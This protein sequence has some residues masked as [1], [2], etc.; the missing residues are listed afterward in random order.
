[1]RKIILTAVFIIATITVTKAQDVRF[2][3]R[4]GVNFTTPSFEV[5]DGTG[6]FSPNTKSGTSFYIGGLA[7]L[8]LHSISEEFRIELQANFT[9]NSFEFEKDFIYRTL[10]LTQ[11]KIPVMA[12]YEVIENGFVKGGFYGAF[13]LGGEYTYKNRTESR[14]MA[15]F[16]YGIPLGLEYNLEEGLFFEAL[17]NIGFADLNDKGS[18][19]EILNRSIQIGIGYKF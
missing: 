6:T 18:K 4:G 8:P 14:D 5:T 12:K 13:T 9:K 11:I 2:G 10:S 19:T 1:M 7:E 3:V 16:D 17:F 15:S